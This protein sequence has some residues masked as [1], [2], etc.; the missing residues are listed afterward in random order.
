MFE[1]QRIYPESDQFSGPNGAKEAEKNW[2]ET[3]DFRVLRNLQEFPRAWVVHNA[4][5]TLPITGLSRETRSGAFQEILYAGDRFWNDSTQR[6]YDPHNLA[7][8]GNDDMVALGPYLSGKKTRASETVK[9][10]YPNP[11]QAV[12]EVNLDSP[13]LV[14]LADIYYPGWELTIDGKAAPIY[15]V[16]GVM[17]GAAVTKGPH[18]LVYTYAPRSFRIGLLVSIGGLAAFVVLALACARWPVDPVL[19]S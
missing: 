3:S 10:T 1:T 15:R 12:L 13:G 9:V 2:I 5:M 6:V 16:N 4:R 8:V 11:Q 7:W 14:I 17:R 18:R 19:A